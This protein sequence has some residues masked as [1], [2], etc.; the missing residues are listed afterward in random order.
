MTGFTSYASTIVL[1]PPRSRA[2][3]PRRPRHDAAEDD[4]SANGITFGSR[5][6]DGPDRQSAGHEAAAAARA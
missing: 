4:A 3:A 5:L 6:K 2:R 1:R